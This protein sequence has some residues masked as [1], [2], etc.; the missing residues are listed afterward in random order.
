MK[1]KKNS[2][3]EVVL[4]DFQALELNWG[5]IFSYFF[6][7]LLFCIFY[8]TNLV[9]LLSVYTVFNLSDNYVN[10]LEFSL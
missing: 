3:D 5:I 8:F 2:K 1:K 7:F 4:K 9:Y 6:L 10:S